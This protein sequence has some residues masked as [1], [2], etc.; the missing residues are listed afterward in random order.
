MQFS[1]ND[2]PFNRVLTLDYLID[3]WR[4]LA[5]DQSSPQNAIARAIALEVDAVPELHGTIE[6]LGVLQTH[7]DILS[8]LMTAVFPIAHAGMGY[9][10]GR[11]GPL[12]DVQYLLHCRV[13]RTGNTRKL[14]SENDGDWRPD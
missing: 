1:A 10:C 4:T 9:C 11:P 3:F 14:P 5:A 2:F 7:Q 6:D 8:R 12:Q 13:G